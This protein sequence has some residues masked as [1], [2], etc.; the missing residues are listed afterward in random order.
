[1]N[2]LCLT[3]LFLSVIFFTGCDKEKLETEKGPSIEIEGNGNSRD[4]SARVGPGF[5][6]EFET[7]NHNNPAEYWD[8]GVSRQYYLKGSQSYI[9]TVTLKVTKTNSASVDPIFRVYKLN[10]SCMEYDSVSSSMGTI[11]PINWGEY[12]WGSYVQLSGFEWQIPM[13]SSP[14]GTVA[15]FT[16]TVASPPPTGSCIEGSISAKMSAPANIPSAYNFWD[17]DH[18]EFVINPSL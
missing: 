7:T 2:K 3:I 1:M 18:L 17:G 14:Q 12:L 6:W 15:T 10:T 4:R 11:Y 9:R 13:S 16:F 8:T 5:S